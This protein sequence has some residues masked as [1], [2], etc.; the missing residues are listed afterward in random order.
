MVKDPRFKMPLVFSEIK[1]S[2]TGDRAAV[3]V[4]LR[5]P[6]HGQRRGCRAETGSLVRTSSSDDLALLDRLAM[7]VGE[8]LN[9]EL[10][11]ISGKGKI[12]RS[13]NLL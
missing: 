8:E 1:L 10:A 12:E 9:S 5:T 6:Q 4:A 13:I 11:K 7:L 2:V 3:F